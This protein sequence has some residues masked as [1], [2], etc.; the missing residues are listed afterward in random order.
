MS[1]MPTSSR[2]QEPGPEGCRLSLV[3][4]RKDHKATRSR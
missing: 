1:E 3:G 4:I 2:A